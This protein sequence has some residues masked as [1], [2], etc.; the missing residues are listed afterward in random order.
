[1]LECHCR[2]PRNWENFPVQSAGPET[3]HSALKQVTRT[4]E[5]RAGGGGCFPLTTRKPSLFS[6]IL[7]EWQ[8][9]PVKVNS[10]LSALHSL[11]LGFQSFK[12]MET[13]SM[14]GMWPQRPPHAH[15][16]ECVWAPSGCG[17]SSAPFQGTGHLCRRW[18]CCVSLTR[19]NGQ[20]SDGGVFIPV[21]LGL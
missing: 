21:C 9:L 11:E 14:A 16:G 18:A 7:H 8:V 17:G 5:P 12:L 3:D 6:V 19:R 15:F 10:F 2:S 1:M 13:C 4:A 20:A